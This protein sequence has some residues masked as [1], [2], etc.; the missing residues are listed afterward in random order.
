VPHREA[1]RLDLQRE[2]IAMRKMALG[3]LIATWSLLGMAAL[4][5]A[6][7]VVVNGS[8]SGAI[9]IPVFD[10]NLGTLTQVDLVVTL[11]SGTPTLGSGL[12]SHSVSPAP[13]TSET[14][15]ISGLHAHSTSFPAYSGGGLSFPAFVLATDNGG[16]H[17][18]GIA[19]MASTTNSAGNH[20]HLLPQHQDSFMYTGA[21]LAPFLGPSDFTIPTAAPTTS[22]GGLHSHSYSAGSTGNAG[23]H[24][25]PVD[26]LSWST[27]TTFTYT[28]AAPVPAMGLGGSLLVG[29]MLAATAFLVIRNRS[30]WSV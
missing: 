22:S 26:T 13:V 12:H 20:S 14:T 6:E 3:F 28:P 7:T 2:E 8:A 11:D 23:S 18:H 29:A 5:G 15:G 9:P 24:S 21:G 25:H 30:V 10:S 17:S 1:S 27:E 4:A 16:S 19:A